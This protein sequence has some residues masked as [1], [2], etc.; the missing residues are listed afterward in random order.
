M[1]SSDL[2]AFTGARRGGYPG[3]FEIADGGTIFLDEIGDMPNDMQIKLLRVIEE[4]VITRIG[5]TKQIY[6]NV[7]IIAATNKNLS[8]ETKKGNFRKDLFYR[9]NVLPIY[10]PPLRERKEDIPL[11]LNYFMSTISKK[12]NKKKVLIPEEYLVT[13]QESRWPGNI[14]EL[15]NYVERLINTESIQV[16]DENSTKDNEENP[17]NNR[18]VT[19]TLSAM[20]KQYIQATLDRHDGNITSCARALGIGRNTLYRKLKSYSIT[21]GTTK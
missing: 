20:E 12:L 16:V 6:V 14:R 10:L 21:N 9:L 11:L 17:K 8:D 19:L 1:C 18:G 7:R 2:G 3:K 5:S 15:E 4:D 13:L